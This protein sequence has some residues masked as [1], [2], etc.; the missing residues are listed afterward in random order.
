MRVL[1][2]AL[3]MVLLLLRGWMGDAMAISMMNLQPGGG[4]QAHAMSMQ[5]MAH[6]MA[7]QSKADLPQDG[8]QA[9]V[10][11]DCA[12][13]MMMAVAAPESA[14]ESAGAMAGCE[15]C[16]VCQA[17]SAVVMGADAQRSL[18][19]ALAQASPVGALPHFASAH[20]QRWQKPPIS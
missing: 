18:T 1:L 6:D 16:A 14:G 9:G 5:N 15:S 7:P 8:A 11:G 20:A 12:G 17:C 3:M 19:L 2:I 13:M 4:A 10:H